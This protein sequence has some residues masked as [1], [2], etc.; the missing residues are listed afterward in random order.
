MKTILLR[1]KVLVICTMII[2]IDDVAF[3]QDVVPARTLHLSLKKELARAIDRGSN[4]L[5]KTQSEDGSWSDADYPAITSLV[6]VALQGDTEEHHAEKKAAILK[7]GYTYILHHVQPDGG[8]YKISSLMN[9]NTAV[10]ILALIVA[11]NPQYNNVIRKARRYII[12]GQQDFGK[13]GIIDTPFDGGI[14][15]GNRYPHSDLSNTVL[16]LE[17]IYHSKHLIKDVATSSLDKLN[18]DAAIQ[19]VQSCQNL[20]ETNKQA[21]VSGDDINRGGFIYFPGNSKAG[22]MKLHDR[23]I[24]LRSYGSISYA[25]MLSYIYAEMH[26]DDI[27]IKAVREW[28]QDNYTLN[29]NPGMGHQGLFYYYYTMSKALHLAGIQYLK[30]SDDKKVNWAKELA[31]KI[32]DLQ[33]ADGSWY[34]DNA[35]WWEKDP[36]LVTAYALL[37]I[38]NIYRSL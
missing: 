35:R 1:Y 9:Y 34:N 28:L 22:E 31:L 18:W 27:R 25:G 6:L 14:G 21:W 3:A 36:A 24:A 38:Q 10:S 5:L 17:A 4:F 19:F 7:K 13:K 32:L 37:T 29:E 30:T 20:P 2:G 23:R 11:D 26:H 15:Y 16:A 12:K 33:R 8:I